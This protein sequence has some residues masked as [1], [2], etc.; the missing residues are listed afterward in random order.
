MAVVGIVNER[1]HRGGFGVDGGGEL[2]ETGW[3]NLTPGS[4]TSCT[5]WTRL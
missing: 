1:R 4:G 5:G 2:E 3:M